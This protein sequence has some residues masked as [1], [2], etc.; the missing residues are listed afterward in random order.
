MN[1]AENG[2]DINDAYV[3]LSTNNTELV[4]PYFLVE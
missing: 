2:F 4:E 3:L 1:N